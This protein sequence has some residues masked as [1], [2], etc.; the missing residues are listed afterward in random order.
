ML[1][2]SEENKIRSLEEELAKTPSNK[3]T[4]HHRGLLKA[5]IAA[6]KD[7]GER[8]A[9]GT[10]AA[11]G[12]YAV[13]K[14]GDASVALVGFPSVGKST[15]LNKITN[16]V[17]EVGGYDFTTLDV[18]PG[19]MEYEGAKIQILDIPGIIEGAAEGKG[20]GREILSVVNNSDLVVI[21]TDV[22]R[23]KHI[24]I[25]KKELYKGKVRLNKTKPDVTIEKTSRDGIVVNT[26]LKLI[27][28]DNKMIRT[29]LNGHRIMNANVIIRT[30]I[31]DE[32]LTDII[33]ANRKYVPML[34]IVNKTDYIG[35]EKLKEI[36]RKLASEDAIFISADKDINIEEVKRRIYDRLSFI[37]IYTKPVGKPIDM[38]EP[39][40]MNKDCD[41]GDVCDRLH[42]TFRKRFRH[43]RIFGKSAKFEGQRKSIDH[44]LMDGDAVEL[45]V[46]AGLIRTKK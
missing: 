18:I 3:G 2:A 32:E 15:L 39:L 23:I 10:G 25:I 1:M 40:I 20:R 29:V 22:F 8:K 37:K 14:S 27:K 33:L 6:L 16:A 36:R 41:V 35:P 11:L 43:S 28:I 30:D 19:M 5:K 17:S 44:V 34:V 13:R 42:K 26:S 12:G 24:E 45:H 46:H 4:Q 21:M 7:T 38:E 31:D 9:S